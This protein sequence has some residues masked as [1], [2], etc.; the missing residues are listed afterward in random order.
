MP[1]IL[2]EK[3]IEVPNSYKVQYVK[4]SELQGL[5]SLVIC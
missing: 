5:A 3:Y 2:P 4:N 1:Y